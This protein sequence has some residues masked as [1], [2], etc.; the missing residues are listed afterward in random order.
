M[1]YILIPFQLE[2][3]TRGFWPKLFP[4][5]P[6]YTLT[7]EVSL[8][9]NNPLFLVDNPF[10]A[11][12]EFFF[13]HPQPLLLSDSSSSY[14][15]LGLLA[16]TD[17]QLWSHI[18]RPLFVPAQWLDH[19]DYED[20][21]DYRHSRFGGPRQAPS[22]LANA[23]DIP[24]PTCPQA[25]SIPSLTQRPSFIWPP[26]YLSARPVVTQA[27]YSRTMPSPGDHSVPKFDGHPSLLKQ[28]FDEVDYLGDS[29]G[30]SAVEK[31][32]HTLHY[33]DFRE[34]KT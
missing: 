16:M 10:A 4:I 30:L 18:A 27:Q 3:T 9:L 31:I 24:L 26:S 8:A 12:A 25:S 34:Y 20:A 6:D 19:E 13:F 2:P 1:L 17:Q 23:G 5:T 29:C 11:T 15:S 33:L 28:F 7:E 21:S 22:T 14:S 32:Q